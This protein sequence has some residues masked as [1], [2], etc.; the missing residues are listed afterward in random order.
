[1]NRNGRPLVDRFR[2]R[3]RTDHDNTPPEKREAKRERR[4]AIVER[5]ARVAGIFGGHFTGAN[6]FFIAAAITLL[7][8][9][10]AALKWVFQ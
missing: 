7:G 6:Q 9:A 3:W 2:D 8:V 5:L 10:A 4:Q 1:M